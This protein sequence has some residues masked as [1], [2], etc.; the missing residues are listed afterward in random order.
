MHTVEKVNR[1]FNNQKQEVLVL[2]GTGRLTNDPPTIH[3]TPNGNKVLSSQKGHRFAIAFNNG[4]DKEADFYSIEAWGK[5]GEN[6]A[7]LGFRGQS[8]EVVGRVR[9]EKFVGNDNV[10]REN[11]I[12]T[13]E[14]FDVK[15]YKEQ[16][17]GA[18]TTADTNS[19][20]SSAGAS[21]SQQTYT[22]IDEDPFANHSGPIEV[23]DDDLPF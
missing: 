20:S 4:K 22:R 8:V 2:F 12:I 11:K 15:S 23:S 14:R 5:T 3:E 13:I 17:T 7:S 21:E 16:G 10:E 6:L 9:T 18:N 1:E 19:G